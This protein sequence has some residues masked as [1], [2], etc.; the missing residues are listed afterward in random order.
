MSGKNYL[1]ASIHMIRMSRLRNFLA[2]TFTL[3]LVGCGGSG[4]K[5]EGISDSTNIEKKQAVYFEYPDSF[6]D[7]EKKKLEEWI[8]INHNHTQQVLGEFPF[9]VHY[10]FHREDSAGQ[11]VIFGHTDR[12]DSV[13][14][15]HFYVDPTY[16]LDDLMADWIA[17]HEISHLAIPR[18]NKTNRWFFEG[19]ATYF[20]RQVMIETGQLQPYQVDSIN[21][22]RIQICKHHFETNSLLHAVCDSLIEHHQWAPVYWIGTSY[23]MKAEEKLKQSNKMNLANVLK[24]F[25][26]CCHQSRMSLE[27]VIADFDKISESTIFSDLH[28]YYIS[29]S[30]REILADY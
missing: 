19:F 29:T 27:Q 9:D 7:D 12:N 1:P 5:E 14:G 3:V 24:E 10:H 30:C 26:M 28:T 18:L 23:F 11:A 4:N 2:L 16:S 21:L 8:I 13:H 17:P 15:A 20:S 25:Q 22:A 6:S